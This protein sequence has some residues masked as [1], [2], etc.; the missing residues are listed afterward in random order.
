MTENQKRKWLSHAV[1]TEQELETLDPD[2]ATKEQYLLHGASLAILMAENHM[3]AADHPRQSYSSEFDRYMDYVA[4]ELRDMEKYINIGEE[5]IARDEA[6]HAEYFIKK[7]R[8]KATSKVMHK[9]VDEA[10]AKHDELMQD[11]PES[12]V[13]ALVGDMTGAFVL[14]MK[15]KSGEMLEP[16]VG[17]EAAANKALS[18]MLDTLKTIF[19]IIIKSGDEAETMMIRAGLNGI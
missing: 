13:A 12:H 14:Y 11:I 5:D 19:G 8:G 2:K 6:R 3:Q 7:A 9:A 1:D 17:H 10:Q 16:G 15:E 18:E 4:D